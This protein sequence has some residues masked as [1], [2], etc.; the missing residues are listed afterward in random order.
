[1]C[2]CPKIG[3]SEAEREQGGALA[4]PS[5]REGAQAGALHAATPS[6]RSDC[7][8]IPRSRLRSHPRIGARKR[9]ALPPSVYIC[10]YQ[11]HLQLFTFVNWAGP[12]FTS[13]KCALHTP[14]G[15]F[16]ALT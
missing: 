4:R 6:L 2:E 8:R 13:V 3:A 12:Q 9:P 15:L 10:K 5:L 14:V 7:G 1:M 16:R 11:L